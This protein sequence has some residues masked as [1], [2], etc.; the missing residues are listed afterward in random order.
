MGAFLGVRSI[1]TMHRH[2]H[3]HGWLLQPLDLRLALPFDVADQLLDGHQG[4]RQRLQH[5]APLGDRQRDAQRL[6]G[7]DAP[8]GASLI[9]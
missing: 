5:R 2:V 8:F 7:G 3:G 1:A 9:T 4:P 6:L